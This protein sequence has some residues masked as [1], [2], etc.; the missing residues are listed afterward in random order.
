MLAKAR[1]GNATI[2]AMGSV[3][4]LVASAVLA[5]SVTGCASTKE[6]MDKLVPQQGGLVAQLRSPSSSATGAVHVFDFRDGVQVQLVISNLMPGAYRIAIHENGNCR[7][8]NLYSAGPAWAPPGWTKPAGDLLPSFITNNDG[9]YNAYVAFV[10]G[11][12]TE[13]PDSIRGKSVVIHWGNL[14]GEAFP[15]APNNRMACGV[16]DSNKPIF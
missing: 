11:V 7:S 15:G 3:E 16:L 4:R 9:N 14:V 5:M 13:G 10:K 8:P 2:G 1:A 12:R 6:G